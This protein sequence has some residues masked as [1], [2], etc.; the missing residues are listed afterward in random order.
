MDGGYTNWTQMDLVRKI[1]EE[2]YRI[3]YKGPII[4]A[5]DHGGPRAR[6]IQA[7]ENWSLSES[8]DWI[9]KSSN[10]PLKPGMTLYM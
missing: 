7:V 1:K 5:I 9:K 2:S 8:M 10:P 6:D 4:V 3:G